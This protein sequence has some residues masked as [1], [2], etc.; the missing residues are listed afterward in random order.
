MVKLHSQVE[1][2]HGTYVDWKYMLSVVQEVHSD[3]PDFLVAR[4]FAVVASQTDS[5]KHRSGPYSEPTYDG[6]TM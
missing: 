1:V 5:L 4:Q 6:W 3:A 2:F